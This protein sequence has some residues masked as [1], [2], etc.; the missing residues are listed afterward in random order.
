MFLNFDYALEALAKRFKTDNIIRGN[1]PRG[2]ATGGNKSLDRGRRIWRFQNNQDK[3][4]FVNAAA[5]GAGISL[6]DANTKT[7]RSCFISPPWSAT[8]MK[9]V[10]FRPHRLGGGFSRQWLVFS[11]TEIERRVRDRVEAR[12]NNLDML[13]DGDLANTA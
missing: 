4:I 2:S 7:P 3:L 10:L 1:R 11:D 13:T 9:Q 8:V 6:H 12:I 5:G